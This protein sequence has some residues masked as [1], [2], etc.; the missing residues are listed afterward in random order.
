MATFPT[1]VDSADLAKRRSDELAATLDDYGAKIAATAKA[2]ESGDLDNY[3]SGL[4]EKLSSVQPPK[5]V[6]MGDLRAIEAQEPAAPVAAPAPVDQSGT[7]QDYLGQLGAKLGFGGQAISPEAEA[8][9]QQYAQGPEAGSQPEDIGAYMDRLG[10]KI[11]RVAGQAGEA[12][13]NLWQQATSGP[14]MQDIGLQQKAR[15]ESA[16]RGE[17]IPTGIDGQPDWQ[18][19]LAKLK[20]ERE[21]ELA[22]PDNVFNK[23]YQSQSALGEALSQETPAM[24]Q[25]KAQGGIVP[26]AADLSPTQR[27]LRRGIGNV[28][29][30]FGTTASWQGLPE[31][32]G[33]LQKIGK[34]FTQQNVEADP[35]QWNEQDFAANLVNP[36]F[37]TEFLPENLPFTLSLIPLAILAGKGGSAA[38]AKAMLGPKMTAVVEYLSAGVGSRVLESAMEAGQVYDQAL[39]GGKTEAEAKRAADMVFALNMPLSAPDAIQFALSFSKLPPAAKSVLSRGIA[40]RL[41]SVGVGILRVLGVMGSEGLEEVYQQGAQQYAQGKPITWDAEMQ[42]S[43]AAG[44]AMGGGM[45]GAGAIYSAAR[46]EQP[47][48]PGRPD[49][50]TTES[51]R[52][53][54][55]QLPAPGLTVKDVGGYEPVS[56]FTGKDAAADPFATPIRR[57]GSEGGVLGGT[58]QGTEA[59]LREL[60]EGEAAEAGQVPMSFGEQAAEAPTQEVQETETYQK[61]LVSR[62]SDGSYKITVLKQT[63]PQALEEYLTE[64]RRSTQSG[65]DAMRGRDK[66]PTSSQHANKVIS[67]IE[68]SRRR[69]DLKKREAVDAFLARLHKGEPIPNVTSLAQAPQ[70]AAGAESL[71]EGVAV[72]V[73]PPLTDNYV[74]PIVHYGERFYSEMSGDSAM[75]I[76]PGTNHSGQIPEM[77]VAN[78]PDLAL[79]QSGKG[80]VVELVPGNLRGQVNTSKPTWRLSYENGD[81]EFLL[82]QNEQADYIAAVQSITVKS[83]AVMSRPTKVRFKALLSNWDSVKNADGSVTWR[84]P[85]DIQVQAA[86]GAESLADLEAQH[87]ALSARQ[88]QLKQE[89]DARMDT[90]PNLRDYGFERRPEY[91]KAIVEHHRGTERLRQERESVA[92]ERMAAWKKLQAAKVTAGQEAPQVEQSV[93]QYINAIRNVDKQKYARAYARYLQR[94]GPAPVTPPA[95]TLSYMAAQA[96]RL[97][98]DSMVKPQAEAPAAPTAQPT[99]ATKQPWEMTKEEYEAQYGKPKGNTTVTGGFS[100]HRQAVEVALRRGDPV[101]ASVLADYPDLSPTTPP[102]EQLELSLLPAGYHERIAKWDDKTLIGETRQLNAFLK[103]ADKYQSSPEQI[104][105]WQA[106]LQSVKQE[107]AARVAGTTPRAKQARAEVQTTGKLTITQQE[108]DNL[109][110]DV[111]DRYR[112]IGS[113]KIEKGISQRGETI[114]GYAHN[115]DAFVISDLSGKPIRY[116]VRLPD[117]RLAHPDELL[118]AQQRGRVVIGSPAA[119]AAPQASKHHVA[120]YNGK[121]VTIDYEPDAKQEFRVAAQRVRDNLEAG[122]KG[123][124]LAPDGKRYEIT[125]DSKMAKLVS[126]EAAPQAGQGEVPQVRGEEPNLTTPEDV[127]AVISKYV[128]PDYYSITRPDSPPLLSI[129]FRMMDRAE[130]EGIRNNERSGRLWSSDPTDYGHISKGNKDKVFVAAKSDPDSRKIFQSSIHTPEQAAVANFHISQSR[131][132]E[133]V[134]AVYESVGARM[135]RTWPA[136]QPWEMTRGEFAYREN[137]PKV[138]AIQQAIRDGKRIVVTTHTRAT[139]LSKPEYIRIQRNGTV[140]IPEGKNWVALT[141]ELLSNTAAQAGVEP[142]PSAQRV[143]HRSEVEDALRRGDPV[144]EA[145]RKEYPELTQEGEDSEGDDS[146]S[147]DPEFADYGRPVE[148]TETVGGRREAPRQGTMNR[149]LKGS[150]GSAVYEVDFGPDA[151][152]RRQVIRVSSNAEVRFLDRPEVVATEEG[153]SIASPLIEAAPAVLTTKQPWEMAKA[154]FIHE[155]EVVHPNNKVDEPTKHSFRPGDLTIDEYGD[156]PYVYR[157]EYV[158]PRTLTTSLEGETR[159]HVV[160][161]PTTQR[162]IEWAK[163]G[164]EAPPITLVRHTGGN[165]NSINRRRLIAAQEAGV[166]RIPVWMEI[167]RHKDLVEQALKEGKPVPASVLADYPDLT[168]KAETPPAE[169]VPTE[170]PQF[171]VKAGEGAVE[172]VGGGDANLAK[173][174][175]S[176]RRLAD[177]MQKQIDEKRNPA[178]AQQIVTARR[179]HIAAGMSEEADRMEKV[180]TVLRGLAD[181][182]EADT[183]PSV[184]S[185]IR[186]RAAVEVVLFGKD[187]PRAYTRSTYLDDVMALTKGKRG[188]AALRQTVQSVLNRKG[189]EG[190]VMSVYGDKEMSAIEDLTKEAQKIGLSSSTAKWISEGLVDFKRV[191][192]AG[193][194]EIDWTEAKAEINKLVQPRSAESNRQRDIAKMERDLIGIDIPGYFPTPKVVVARML[195]AADIRPGMNVLEP[196]AGKGNIADAI[197]EAEPEANLETVEQQRTLAKILEAKGHKIA[198]EDF[199]AYEGQPDRIVMNPP[200]ENG[201]DID[202]VRRAY[203]L[204]KPGGR[205][206]AIMSEGPF[207]R[208]D[209]KAVAFRD[210]LDEIDGTSEKLPEGA[211]KSSERSTGVNTRLVILDK[212]TAEPAGP[213]QVQAPPLPEEAVMT[214]PGRNTGDKAGWYIDQNDRPLYVTDG[215]AFGYRGP[216]SKRVAGELT[217]TD[218]SY[219]KPTGKPIYTPDYPESRYIKRDERIV[220]ENLERARAA[221]VVPAETPATPEPTGDFG[222]TAPAAAISGVVGK[223]TEATGPDPNKKYTFRYRVVSLDDLVPSHLDTLAANPAFPAELQP[224]LRERAASQVQIE[225]IAR[226]L[227]PAGLLDDGH[228]LDRGPMIVGPDMVVESG[229]GRTLGLRLARSQFPSNFATYQDALAS[230]LPGYGI[231][232][233]DIAGIVDP[234]LVRERVTEVDR[235]TFVAEANQSTVLTMS[236]LEQALQ[237]AGRITDTMLTSLVVGEE[238]S[239]DVALKSAA[240][241][242]LTRAFINAVPTNERAALM[243]KNGLLSIAGLLRLKNA[244]FAKTYPG[245][246]GQRLATAFME[247][248]DQHVKNIE[249]GLFGSLPAMARAEGLIRSGQRDTGLS[250]TEDLS[251]AVDMLARLREE[252]TRVKDWL[253]QESMFGRELSPFQEKLLGYL[254]SLGRSAKGMR[255]FINDYAQAVEDA[256]PTGQAGMFGFTG[257]TKEEIVE[258]ISEG[259]IVAETEP[260]PRTETEPATIPQ[261]ATV[262][263]ESAQLEGRLLEQ[264]TPTEPAATL[265]LTKSQA[266]KVQQVKDKLAEG[267]QPWTSVEVYRRGDNVLVRRFIKGGGELNTA[268]FPSG[269]ALQHKDTLDGWTLTETIEAPPPVTKVPTTPSPK[270]PAAKKPADA[271]P[272]PPTEPA[273]AAAVTEQPPTPG[274]RQPAGTPPTPPVVTPPT[275]APVPPV[276]PTTPPPVVTPPATGGRGGRG[277]RPPAPPATPPAPPVPPAPPGRRRRTPP[278]PPVPPVPVDDLARVRKALKMPKTD[279][280]D[281]IDAALQRLI[282][283]FYDK[284][285]P[286]KKLEQQT[287][288][289]VHKLAQI[290][291]GSEASGESYLIE[292]VQPVIESVGKD[293]KNLE[294]FMVAW[295]MKD[296]K[297]INPDALLAGSAQDPEHALEQLLAEI[298][299]QHFDKIEAAAEELWELN[300]EL[301]LKPYLAAGVLSQEA[302]DAIRK[303]WPHYIPFY[304]QGFDWEQLLQTF[305]PRSS[306]NVGE[307]VIK[308]LSLDGSERNLVHPLANWQAQVIKAREVVFR[309]NAALALRDALVDL[310]VIEGEEYVKIRE[311]RGADWGTLRFYEDGQ[312]KTVWVPTLYATVAKGLEAEPANMLAALMRKTAAPLRHGAVTYNPSFLVVNPIRDAI[313][314]YY[315]EGLI[316][317]SP[318]VIKAWMS[319]IGKGEMWHEAAR[320]GVLMSGITEVSKSTDAMGKVNRLGGIRLNNIA[321]VLLLLP[322]FIAKANEISEQTTRVAVFHKLKGQGITELEAAVRSRDATVDFAKSGNTIKMVN[323]AIP[324]LNAGIQGSANTLRTIKANPARALLYGLPLGLVSILFA[325]LNDRDDWDDLADDIPA[326]EYA[327]NWVLL[328]GEGKQ[329]VDPQKPGAKPKRFPIYVKIPKGP[330]GAFL[331]APAE[332]MMRVALGRKDRTTSEI[333]LDGGRTMLQAMMPFEPSVSGVTPP[334]LGTGLSLAANYDFFRNQPIVPESEK[335][336]SAALQYGRDTPKT[337]VALGEA[338]GISPRMWE[339]FFKDLGAGAAGTTMWAGDQALGQAGYAPITP[340]EA[341]QQQLS[342][343]EQ[344]SKNPIVGRF[345]GTKATAENSYGWEQLNKAVAETRQ[346]FGKLDEPRRLDIKL[347]QAAVSIKNV[348]LEPAERAELQ[349]LSARKVIEQVKIVT[350]LPVYRTLSDKNKEYLI[351]LAM[352]Q[353]R[354][355]AAWT[356][357]SQLGTEIIKERMTAAGTK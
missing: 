176:L 31:A 140:Q 12:V 175:A 353:A 321:D 325:L 137:A 209:K 337:M 254:D 318:V 27:A 14:N 92:A 32:G 273:A 61:V 51:A 169:K 100:Q 128:D 81:A 310:G 217:G 102:A 70:A 120:I 230:Q 80:V 46:G 177:G 278:A 335:Q 216:Y 59:G 88:D 226:E 284:N 87:S 94:G 72:K 302:Y 16:F 347:G 91:E 267:R 185:G 172:Q 261:P 308:I 155:R 349:R 152:G 18:N 242:Q 167:G 331:T 40:Q 55:D 103:A 343:A 219:M 210:W 99:Q 190:Y 227:N 323:I 268:Y 163:A 79:G 306:A 314:A 319:T 26:T 9:G 355:E 130:W 34:D 223:E 139:L 287:G 171:G 183:L 36:R 295:R 229:N 4:G 30:N 162:Y 90:T 233:V 25:F 41:G 33:T 39:Q 35:F 277:T 211:F 1:Y 86:V 42:Q 54:V 262:D 200:F 62:E 350:A 184:L 45:G 173:R 104:A 98:L 113:P 206:V 78:S 166:E 307:E 315:R 224:R 333:V 322:R 24:R 293:V 339:F 136:V 170:E 327:N 297:A 328:I 84:R 20:A 2:Q 301:V 29:E 222:V 231:Q 282:R 121:E 96:I 95:D 101:P 19:Y 357:L 326:Y 134:I 330:M 60:A 251:K 65:I 274:T 15:T 148:V 352:T 286:L 345:V 344:V 252:G 192:A 164:H 285:H 159:E 13:G 356:F 71:A 237:D 199:F 329:E 279:P 272:T 296:L 309:N 212:P 122:D 10:S 7:L 232:A 317:F 22:Q 111:H 66:H 270:P 289:P 351:R 5:P 64:V 158:D 154:E 143:F 165:L 44:A 300:D 281:A 110:Q 82:R 23:L 124:V 106:R 340:G 131:G 28:V 178:I 6:G 260:T 208:N 275:A 180:Q 263:Q 168:A 255:G 129:V 213:S 49:L 269:Q 271:A 221:A 160:N 115:P 204:V 76:I 303:R 181:M 218:Q 341:K 225:K 348:E 256:P 118:E 215:N 248:L 56:M 311:Q 142:T 74:K 63:S 294:A 197:R 280:R 253:G 201:Q 298:G 107:Q 117:G 105:G 191:S 141:D 354:E 188:L 290:V 97:R 144:P 299:Q 3:L 73:L 259:A 324:F 214:H 53:L 316:P 304:R 228:T 264:P 151:N 245:E 246:A 11:G 157:L 305:P 75:M 320:S 149:T 179:S 202:H 234:V 265:P 194:T 50:S 207:F 123:Y 89:I 52:R 334:L 257:P 266:E 313:S 220:R 243:D 114:I 138:E 8:A 133:D 147:T 195:E 203:D 236:P 47:T 43:F 93:E 135:P 238:Q 189:P 153:A 241:V 312:H 187:F 346:E 145:V 83:D 132:I 283:D 127:D 338:T 48:T 77:W 58:P 126:T 205:V 258:R 67:S 68:N 85:P 116:Y 240:N 288:I 37:Y 198:G 108:N 182:T 332:M 150:T 174:A 244:L 125:R 249:Q 17:A 57:P 239:I 193:I 109:L 21:V 247:T 196:S 336:R 161:M 250:L 156:N 112:E 186:T 235:P 276:T 119:E 38:A 342:T 291:P 69:D 146:I 292:Y